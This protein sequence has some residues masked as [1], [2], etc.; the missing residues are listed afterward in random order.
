VEQKAQTLLGRSRFAKTRQVIFQSLS[1]HSP[2]DAT[3]HLV[4]YVGT[5]GVA[6]NKA[7]INSDFEGTD[8]YKCFA[9]VRFVDSL[10]VP[11]GSEEHEET[12]SFYRLFFLV[13]N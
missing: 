8:A 6:Q 9:S 1:D 11:S 4:F 13:I 3:V 2:A 7:I 5:Q 10:T 12:F